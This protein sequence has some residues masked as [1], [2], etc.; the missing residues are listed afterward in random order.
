MSSRFLFFASALLFSFGC[1]APETM[2]SEVK[3]QSQEEAS[4]PTLTRLVLIPAGTYTPL[5]PGKG[6][7]KSRPRHAF[8]MEV[9]AVTNSQFLE[10]VRHNPK[11]R[12][13][14]ISPLMA[15]ESYL[16]QWESDLSIP[17]NSANSPVT[18]VTWF[19]A[20]AYAK[21]IG[22]RLPTLAEW[23][24]VGMASATAA[25]GRDEKGYNQR[26]LNWYARPTPDIP[27][28]VGV[29]P[30]NYYG[31]QDMHGLIWEWIED[32]NNSLSNGESRGD[33]GLDRNLFCGAAAIGAAD[34]SDYAAFMRFAFRG[35]LEGRFTVNNLGFRCAA[36]VPAP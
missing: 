7:P 5:Y 32:F 14:Q 13:S 4:T 2:G 25:N 35:S 6:E 3:M 26:I 24:S 28:P 12:R 34:P 21:W 30:P 29:S 9:H 17:P 15:D 27:E 8:L 20:R 31:V 10:F 19:S 33:S 22:R 36:N 11:W 18:N 23:E 1:V 16:R